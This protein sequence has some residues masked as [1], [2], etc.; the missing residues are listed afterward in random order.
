MKKLV[1]GRKDTT[2][3]IFQTVKGKTLIMG[4][5]GIVAALIIGGVGVFSIN[6]NAKN[7]EV[8]SLVNDISVLQSENLANDAL[9][10][11]YVDENYLNSTLAN[12]DAM[13]EKGKEL[14]KSAGVGYQSTIGAILE[15]VAKDKENFNEIKRIHSERGYDVGIGKY[16]AFA[17]ASDQLSESFKTLVNNND[18]I[19]I[20]WVDAQM[21]VGGEMVEVDGN[22]YRKMIYHNELPVAVKRNNLV[23]RVGGTFTYQTDY[24]IKNIKLINGNDVVPVDLTPVEKLEKSGDGL[25]NAELVDFGGDRAIKVTGKYDAANARWEEVSTTFSIKDYDL[26][27]YPVLE[28][29]LY[30]NPSVPSGQDYKY[31]GAISGVYSFADNLTKWDE[32]MNS[33]SKLVVEG[34]DVT[35]KQAEIEALIT[36]IE[37]NIPKY[38][39][40]PSL[41]EASLACL[42][43][44]KELYNE[45]KTIDAQTLAIKADNANINT[46]L[47]DLCSTVQNEAKNEMNT[48]RTMVTIVILV[49]LIVSIAVLAM[50]L[51]TVSAGINKSVQSFQSAIEEIAAGKIYVRAK[52]DGKDEFAMFAKN[53]NSFMDTLEPAMTKV[54]K[55]TGVLAESG[56]ML[57]E[58][59]TKT[60]QVAGEINETISEISKGAGEQ[61]RDIEASSQKVVDMRTN[62]DQILTSISTLSEK[63]GQ[64][65]KDGQ[66][67]KDT[68]NSL[69]QSSDQTTDAFQKIADQVRKTDE[70]V[71]KIQDAVS[72][73]ASVANQINLLSL[74][75]SIEAARAGEAGRG[76]AVVATEISKLADQTNQS[77]A[78]I[79]QIIHVLSDESNR[80]VGTI[81][82][83]TELIQGQKSSIDTTYDKFTGVSEGIDFTQDAVRD[84]LSQA[85]SCENA[86][87][88]VV[89]LMTNL[90]A[91]SEEN[92]ASAET[93]SSAMTELN[94]ETAR[95]ADTASELKDLAD[96][97]K[98]DLE[99][100]QIS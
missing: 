29:E 53:L 59:A 44:K 83:V 63:S 52:A 96:N 20:H 98:E 25:E 77:A 54:K 55:M 36:E 23:L 26:E 41:A 2:T 57:E 85:E 94:K 82:E 46:T 92:A 84:V 73:I 87:E 30:L 75:A 49:V 69:T 3:N 97:I 95:L 13:E 27:K 50:N 22:S 78:V 100:F 60:K 61:A 14:K 68:M 1:K 7:A 24:Y 72:L 47:T 89:D 8:V 86:G 90:S 48:V 43:E 5:L 16:Q 99:F 71:N 12:L 39:T 76:F 64:M 32:L 6:R 18:W 21:G 81:N 19:E 79:D 58:S 11:Y 37:E 66:E 40:D 51:V 65:S 38:T 45:L 31:G 15:N 28:Y 74:N 9:Y 56:E 93:T 34:K 70:S 67:A 17:A 10:Q 4:A 91:I 88:K 35:A 42:T 80:T 33:Y 62:I